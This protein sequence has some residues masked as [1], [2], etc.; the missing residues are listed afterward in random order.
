V[1]DC[2]A[3]AYKVRLKPDTTPEV[4]LKPDTTPEVWLKSDTTPD[5]WLKPDTTP[6]ALNPDAAPDIS[7]TA[8]SSGTAR[9]ATALRPGCEVAGA[10]AY[11]GRNG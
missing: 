11:V 9:L 1:R 10:T 3:A 2:G 7:K 6:E 8:V 4:R 5:V